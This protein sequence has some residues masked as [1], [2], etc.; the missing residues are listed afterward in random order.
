VLPP[1]LRSAYEERKEAIQQRLADFAAVSRT[2]RF[3][4]LCFCLLTPQ[5]SAVH[6]DQ[7]IARLKEGNFQYEPYDP[8]DVLREPLHYIRFHNVKAQR[9]L[10]LQEQWPTVDEILETIHD[11]DERRRMLVEHVNGLGMKEASHF[12]RNIGGRGLAIL[13]RHI[14]RYLVECQAISKD[15]R[16]STYIQYKDVESLFRQFSNKV[17]ID[18]DEL[19]LLFWSQMTGQILK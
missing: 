7:V 13:D 3:Y 1:Y 9:L 19:D 17:E 15:I 8:V 4:E 11:P 18:M 2:D 14:L 12:L 5:S 16:V 6:A 10:R